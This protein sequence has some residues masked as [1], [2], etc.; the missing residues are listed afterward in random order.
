M[1]PLVSYHIP[2][3]M[4]SGDIVYSDGMWSDAELRIEGR[5][6]RADLV[7]FGL[8]EF[9]VVLGMDCLSRHGA[10]LDCGVPRVSF[11]DAQGTYVSYRPLRGLPD[12]CYYSDVVFQ[13]L[14]LE[15]GDV[16]LLC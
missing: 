7:V 2:V 1:G 15:Q 5:A 9:D 16:A 4:P 14:L 13:S 6:F 12:L 8:R 10:R 11:R 3:S